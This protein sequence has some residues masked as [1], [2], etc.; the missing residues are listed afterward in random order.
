[1]SA[2]QKKQRAFQKVGS[3]SCI[4]QHAS[5]KHGWA[6]FLPA[7]VHRG[8]E[9]QSS[10]AFLVLPLTRSHAR[11]KCSQLH[12][13]ND[14]CWQWRRKHGLLLVVLLRQRR[15]GARR[16]NACMA[17]AGSILRGVSGVTMPRY[18][19]RVLAI[20]SCK[21]VTVVVSIGWQRP[22]CVAF[23]CTVVAVTADRPN[24]TVESKCADVVVAPKS[25][26]VAVAA[27]YT[28]ADVAMRRP[29]VAA[30]ASAGVAVAV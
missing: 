24:V 23:K 8:L 11:L 7:L 25:A 19:C 6:L 27:D 5:S 10:K 14:M 12:A 1:M 4:M 15:R 13:F 18:L 20:V 21:H 30:V 22:A 26:F 16:R 17:I 2:L 9:L 29:L 3:N 28:I